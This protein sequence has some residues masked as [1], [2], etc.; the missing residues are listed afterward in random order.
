[1]ARKYARLRKI[2]TIRRLGLRASS[3]REYR[4]LGSSRKSRTGSKP[5]RFFWITPSLVPMLPSHGGGRKKRRRRRS[6]AANKVGGAGGVKRWEEGEKRWTRKES[7]R[8][9]KGG[10]VRKKTGGE[11]RDEAKTNRCRHR[12]GMAN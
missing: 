6:G 11:C 5:L 2:H 8:R 10:R 3:G 4:R 1:M 12:G 9:R 7:V